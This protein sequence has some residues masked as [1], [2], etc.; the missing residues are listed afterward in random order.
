MTETLSYDQLFSTSYEQVLEA[1][2]RENLANDMPE[3]YEDLGSLDEKCLDLAREGRLVIVDNPEIRQLMADIK[4]PDISRA[5]FQS[6]SMRLIGHLMTKASSI[7]EEEELPVS[8]A[9]SVRGGL[10]FYASA[11]QHFPGIEHG[12]S[13]QSRDETTSLPTSDT[14]KLSNYS[15]RH[16]LVV[17]FMLATGGSLVDLVNLAVANG[18]SELTTVTAFSTPQGIVRAS[19]IE[20]IKTIISLPLE[21][22]LNF[23]DEDHHS[24]IVGGH[25]PNTMLGD[26]GD[27]FHGHTYTPS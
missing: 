23:I 9:V 24:F 2:E 11:L 16:T 26:F 3:G 5:E 7:L 17:D 10:P 22:G 12:F 27:R 1:R 18:A 19:K 13:P 8:L 15:D 25:V 20:G 14:G 21:A 6:M 4:N